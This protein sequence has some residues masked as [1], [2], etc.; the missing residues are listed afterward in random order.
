MHVSDLL[1]AKGSAV[2]TIRAGDNV[3]TLL[4]LL[5]ENHI[6]AAVVSSGEGAVDGIVS[7]RDVVRALARNGPA[8]LSDPVSSIMTSDVRTCT[9]ETDL[10]ELSRV[11]TA[12][13]FRHVPVLV[14]GRLAG[15]VSIGDVVKSRITEL[16]V[17]RDSLSTYITTAAT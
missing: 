1:R 10:E 5:A 7:E 14:N 9:P 4:E 3:T 15:I 17:E 16:E 11:M 2:T 6:G 13:R 12:G 8:I